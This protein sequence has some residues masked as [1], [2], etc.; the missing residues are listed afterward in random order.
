MTLDTEIDR[1]TLVGYGL[2]IDHLSVAFQP[3]LPHFSV[4][5]YNYANK[6]NIL[7]TLHYETDDLT[8][9]RCDSDPDAMIPGWVAR[10]ELDIRRDRILDAVS[11][12]NREVTL[13]QCATHTGETWPELFNPIIAKIRDLIAPTE[14]KI[15]DSAKLLRPENV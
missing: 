15:A 10:F 8:D 4:A 6:G 5:S 12:E 2:D 14:L 13:R 7:F 3:T 11:P 1:K 9:P